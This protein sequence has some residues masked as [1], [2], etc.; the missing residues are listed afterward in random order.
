M[1]LSIEDKQKIADYV[2]N[3]NLPLINQNNRE[4][5]IKESIYTKYI[6]RLIDII[7]SGVCLIITLPINLVIGIGT[8]FDVGKPIFFR[9]K[10][11]GKNGEGFIIVK[12]RNMTNDTDEN[13]NLLPISQRVTRFGAIMRKTSL[14]ELLNFWSVFKGDMSLIGPR[15]L[16]WLYLERFSDRHNMRHAVRPGLECPN[17]KKGGYSKDW[18]EQLENDIWYVENVSFLNDCKAIICLFKMVFNK[19]VRSEHAKIGVGDFIGY[20]ENGIAFGANNIPT[21]YLKILDCEIVEVK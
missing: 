19:K 10:R 5:V 9:Q 1:V 18:N 21:E 3:K 8:F 15:P 13:G 6:K 16:A 14:D 2:K 12:F 17:L 20:D 4:V 11:P 7:V